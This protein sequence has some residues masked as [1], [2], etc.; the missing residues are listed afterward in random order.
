MKRIVIRMV[1]GGVMLCAASWAC[2]G[3]GDTTGPD[4]MGNIPFSGQSSTCAG[5]APGVI[6][7]TQLMGPR[8]ASL[9]NVLPGAWLARGTYDLTGTAYT[10][11]EI[12]ITF[13]GTVV[14]GENGQSIEDVPYMVNAANLSGTFEATGGFVRITSGSGAPGVMIASGSSALECIGLF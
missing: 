14:T 10:T 8:G 6:H 7:V 3:D 9:T 11:A 4:A 12:F 5:F 2:G 1:L 13:E